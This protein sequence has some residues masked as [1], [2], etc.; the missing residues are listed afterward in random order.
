MSFLPT[1][2][3]GS[4]VAAGKAR[5]S[6]ACMAT[7]QSV[8]ACGSLPDPTRI[9]WG[10]FYIAVIEFCATDSNW[11]S[12]AAQTNQVEQYGAELFAWQQRLASF[13]CA[14][15]NPAFDPNAASTMPPAT[16]NLLQW[17]M[18]ATLAVAGAYVVGKVVSVIPKPAPR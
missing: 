7:D 3:Y 14:S 16:T 15:A 11:W 4:T 6:A 9:G 17:G 10:Q 8:Q 1:I 18:Y 2:V 13:N 12:A 5:L